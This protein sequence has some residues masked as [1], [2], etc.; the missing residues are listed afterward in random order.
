LNF[1][2][3]RF[4]GVVN[5]EQTCPFMPFRFR[6]NRID[7]EGIVVAMKDDTRKKY[8]HYAAHCLYLVTAATDPD[9]RAIQ[10]EM[11][12]EWL[13]LADAVR[14]PSRPPQMQME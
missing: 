11:A 13:K 1:A 4:E 14:R 10:R 2:V 9:S 6:A 3:V 8:A 5:F 12:S 7:Q